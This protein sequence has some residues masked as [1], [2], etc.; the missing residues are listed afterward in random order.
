LW[1]GVP[2]VT[3]LG[4]SF[5]N[6]VAASLLT[7]I[8]APELITASLEDYEALALAL[9]RDPARLAA[10]KAKLAVGRRTAPLFDAD[11]FRRHIERGYEMMMDIARAGDAP[12]PFDVPAIDV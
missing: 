1:T 4:P 12:H 9:A 2:I 3:V 7:A 8:G 11:R 10:L 6:R 5:A